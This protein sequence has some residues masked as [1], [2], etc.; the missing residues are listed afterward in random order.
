MIVWIA[1]NERTFTPDQFQANEQIWRI[2][3]PRFIACFL[4]PRQY[5]SANIF[6]EE[7]A[8]LF[9]RYSCLFNQCKFDIVTAG[10]KQGQFSLAPAVIF[11]VF[12]SLA[13]LAL[14]GEECWSDELS[15]ETHCSCLKAKKPTYVQENFLECVPF[16]H[17][18]PVTAKKSTYV[19]ERF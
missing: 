5:F 13:A 14:V 1:T 8:W 10:H 4:K 6:R 18:T 16:Q 7:H 15:L 11:T 2:P 19:L 3:N 17:S 9:L 12:F